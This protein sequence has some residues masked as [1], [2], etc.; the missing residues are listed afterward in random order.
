MVIN[1]QTLVLFSALFMAFSP[2]GASLLQYVRETRAAQRQQLQTQAVEH[3]DDL[4]L[5]LDELRKDY[6]RKCQEADHWRGLYEACQHHES[7]P[8]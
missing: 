3:R 8:I 4:Q 2:F 7:N 5:I 6:D 1:E